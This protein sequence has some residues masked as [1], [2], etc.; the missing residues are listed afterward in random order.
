[1]LLDPS[2]RGPT[3][4]R[5]TLAGIAMVLAF[6]LALVLLML[7]YNGYFDKSV[8][9]VAE[10]TSTGD[11]LPEHADVKFRGMVVGTVS[12]VE[13]VAKGERQRAGIDLKPAVAPTIPINVTAR[14]I[15]SNIFGVTAIELVDNGA[16]PAGLRAGA[17]IP[18]DT[19]PGTTQ[20]QTTL[21]VLRDVLDKIQPEKLGRV[22]ATLATA[23]EPGARVPGS[24]IERLD[25]WLTQVRATP[26]IGNLL[27]DLGRATTELSRSAPELVGVLSESVT[28]ARTLTERRANLIALLANASNTIDSVNGLFAANPNSAKELVPGLDQLFGSLAQDPDAIPTTARN[29]NAA[30]AKLVTVFHFGPSRQMVWAMDISFTPFQQYTAAE[31]P[32][33]GAQAGPRCGGPSVPEVAP[34]QEYPAQLTPR[35][36]DAAGPAP[37]PVVPAVPGLPG[38]SI[39]G[40]PAIPGL[41]APAA[42]NQGAVPG[43]RPIAAGRGYAG[44][45]AIVGGQPTAAQLL[46][47][48]PLLAGGSVTVYETS[49]GNR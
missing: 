24:T 21:T 22:L 41:T 7:R 35:W 48:T 15:P 34:A 20:L 46:L 17:I 16:A 18:E 3:A 10:L 9:V 42:D 44:V 30:L 40:L 13:V 32:R 6:A 49:G 14:P 29:L 36:L 45:A 8:P 23:L 4:R 27:G 2:G 47:L 38:I 28:A 12:G 43:V 37:V 25:T 26:G 33:Y 39:P 19:G 1:M 31:C 5:L 11:G